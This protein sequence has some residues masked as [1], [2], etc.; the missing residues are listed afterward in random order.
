MRVRS[1][2]Q[3]KCETIRNKKNHPVMSTE[4]KASY[5]YPVRKSQN[6]YRKKWNS[7]KKRRIFSSNNLVRE[8]FFF[9]FLVLRSNSGIKHCNCWANSQIYFALTSFWI[10]QCTHQSFKNQ[11]IIFTSTNA[12]RGFNLFHV[13]RHSV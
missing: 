12:I 5:H 1:C 10:F 13:I 9:P 11:C 2:V 8:Y 6:I 7:F 4:L 3:F